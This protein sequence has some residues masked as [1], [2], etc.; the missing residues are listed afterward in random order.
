MKIFWIRSNFTVEQ[1]ITKWK[2]LQKYYRVPVCAFG[3]CGVYYEDNALEKQIAVELY[4][5][6]LGKEYVHRWQL[7]YNIPHDIREDIK[8]LLKS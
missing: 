3:I 4:H 1:D 2:S 5:P 8:R 7:D 6:V